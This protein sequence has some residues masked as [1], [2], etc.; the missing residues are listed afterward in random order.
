MSSTKNIKSLLRSTFT[1][2]SHIRRQQN[3]SL[4]S[5]QSSA[6]CSKLQK[7]RKRLLNKLLLFTK[8]REKI[9]SALEGINENIERYTANPFMTK[10]LEVVLRIKETNDNRLRT[11]NKEISTLDGL[12]S[13][14]KGHALSE[15][16]KEEYD[17]LRRLK[18]NEEMSTTRVYGN[19]ANYRGV[20]PNDPKFKLSDVDGGGRSRRRRRRRRSRRY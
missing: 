19:E 2:S 3:K 7:E 13:K 10:Q 16:T 14:N 17:V 18:G 12:L 5:M 1:P 4:K 6:M 9:V 15:C 11:V 20:P 8:E